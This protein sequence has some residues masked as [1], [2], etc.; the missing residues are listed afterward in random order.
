MQIKKNIK[1]PR[2][3]PLCGEF[4]GDR[5]I[6]RTNGQQ[7]GKC[8][9]MMTS[10]IYFGTGLGWSGAIPGGFA[11]QF[12]N[13]RDTSQ[14]L[15]SKILKKCSIPFII[16]DVRNNVCPVFIHMRPVYFT[17]YYFR[18]IRSINVTYFKMFLKKTYEG[19]PLVEIA[20]WVWVYRLTHKYTS[21]H[22]DTYTQ[23]RALRSI[24][25]ACSVL[26]VY[27]PQVPQP[28]P[29]NPHNHIQ[30][31]ITRFGRL[32]AQQWLLQ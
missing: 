9:Y 14:D 31:C 11:Y 21:A 29:L 27:P 6:P 3:W 2:H 26:W 30:V 16:T 4:T 24:E 32:L 12:S 22:T 13:I 17:L 5:W 25:L 20:S 10:S 7:R 15:V 19:M 1:A 8:F 18:I 28:P 23:L